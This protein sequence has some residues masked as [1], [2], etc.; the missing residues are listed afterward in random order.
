ML[1][2]TEVLVNLLPLTPETQG[3]LNGESFARMRRGGFLI[4]VGRGEHLVDNDLLVAL[5]TASSTAPHSTCSQ[6]SRWR[7]HIRSG[8]IPKSSSRRTMPA[9][10]ALKPSRPRWLRP[11]TRF[12]PGS[13]RPT[14]SIV[15]AAIEHLQAEGLSGAKP[16]PRG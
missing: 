7:R 1:D 12:A 4:Q 14:P 8:V 5:K 16:L 3:I 10:S 2:E 15:N 6:R 9:R 11:P 13:D